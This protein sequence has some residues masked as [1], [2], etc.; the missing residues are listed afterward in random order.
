MS[1]GIVT[2]LYFVVLLAVLLGLVYL[3][4]RVVRSAWK[5]P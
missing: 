5:K 2:V 1:F 4:T 3:V